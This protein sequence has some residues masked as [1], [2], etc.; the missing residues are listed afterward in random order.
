M[1]KL[2]FVHGVLEGR[3]GPPWTY[4]QTFAFFLY[5][6]LSQALTTLNYPEPSMR[7]ETGLTM[8]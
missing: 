5:S 6:P 7:S 1:S 8:A 3:E 4:V 2:N